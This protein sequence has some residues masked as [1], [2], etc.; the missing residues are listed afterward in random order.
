MKSN[1]RYEEESLYQRSKKNILA[2]F[3]IVTSIIVAIFL[4]YSILQVIFT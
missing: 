4:T 1:I 2:F 3:P